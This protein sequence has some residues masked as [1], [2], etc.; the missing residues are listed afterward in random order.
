MSLSFNQTFSEGISTRVGIFKD[1]KKRRHDPVLES[2]IETAHITY[3]AAVKRVR[4]C[5][6]TLIHNQFFNL[7]PI[8]YPHPNPLLQ[9]TTDHFI[10]ERLLQRITKMIRCSQVKTQST[11]PTPQS[12]ISTKPSANLATSG[13]PQIIASYLKDDDGDQRQV[14]IKV[15]HAKFLRDP[16]EKQVESCLSLI[17]K[18]DVFL[19]AP[20][21]YGKSCIPKLFNLM[22]PKRSMPIVLVLNLLDA[23]G[24]DQVKAKGK[25]GFSAINLTRVTFRTKVADEIIAGKYQFVYVSPEIFLNSSLFARVFFSKSFQD[26]LILKVVD[27]AHLI[28]KWGLAT[29]GEADD[30][31]AH[32]QLQDRTPFRPSYGDLIERFLATET[33]PTLLM[34]ATCTPKAISRILSSLKTS[35]AEIDMHYAEL[36]RSKLRLIQLSVPHGQK[37]WEKISSMILTQSKISDSDIPPTLVYCRTQDDTYSALEAINSARGNEPDTNNGL[38]TCVRRYHLVTGPQDKLARVKDFTGGVFPI[39]ACTT[40]LGMGQDWQRVRRVF[41][42][43]QSDPADM[44]QMA[45]RAGRDGRVSVAFLLVDPSTFNKRKMK[46]LHPSNPSPELFAAFFMS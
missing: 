9:R 12:P 45:G 36:T 25:A 42:V 6:L 27:E 2:E 15:Y 33:V 29:D 14:L 46:A 21:G 43:G 32:T 35:P 24:D 23:L 11:L 39:M 26:Q 7:L 41:V 28:Y 5:S 4:S 37:S 1:L 10:Q 22:F 30:L 8:P 17:R 38:S 40:A 3:L 44:L 20:T 18:R 16:K 13:K 31:K 34:S 19:L